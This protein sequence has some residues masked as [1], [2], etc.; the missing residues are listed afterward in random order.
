MGV[1]FVVSAVDETRNTARAETYCCVQ[2]HAKTV[3]EFLRN[4]NITC[5]LYRSH[6]PQ[7]LTVLVIFPSIPQF[8]SLLMRLSTTYSNSFLLVFILVLF[9]LLEIAPNCLSVVNIPK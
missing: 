4:Q 5:I 1:C 6:I 3:M 2:S 8:T 9:C 7:L